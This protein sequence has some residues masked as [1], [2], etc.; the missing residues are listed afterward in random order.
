[1]TL[2]ELTH[3][4]PTRATL[5]SLTQVLATIR[6]TYLAPL[7]NAV[8]LALPVVPQGLS[9]GQLPIGPVILNL[10]QATIDYQDRTFPIDASFHVAHLIAAL[11]DDR[12]IPP[13][14]HPLPTPL[15]IDHIAEYQAALQT[16]YTALARFR[17]R[18]FGTM[19][20]A[21]VWSHGFDLSFLAFKG[22][23][24]DEHQQPHL[25]FGFSPASTG[26]PRPYLYVYT[27]P[28]I[29]D[30]PLPRLARWYTEAWKGIVIDYDPLRAVDDPAGALED[31]LDVIY[32]QLMSRL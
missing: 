13:I 23:D 17:A 7:P 6:K 29:T 21:V 24:P 25:N 32:H 27:Y 9:T 1:M 31:T 18:L 3:W 22:P 26:F 8:H 12:P 10:R 28:T 14:A 5:H 16:I 15:N 11:P 19:T 4:T 20:P 30:G 2:P